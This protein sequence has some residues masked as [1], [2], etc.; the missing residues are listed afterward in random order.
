MHSA[1]NLQ[2]S[3]L[4][5][6]VEADQS[7]PA[8]IGHGPAHIRKNLAGAEG[9]GDVVETKHGDRSILSAARRGKNIVLRANCLGPRLS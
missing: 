5:R 4:A 7:D 2:Q 8:V 3:G 1:D 9:L 6:A